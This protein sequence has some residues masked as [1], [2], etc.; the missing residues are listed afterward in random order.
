MILAMR[1]RRSNLL[2]YIILN[3]LVS[4]TTTWG[5]LSA[6]DYLH[7]RSEQ[8]VQG[9]TIMTRAAADAIYKP[10]I[11]ATQPPPA[12]LTPAPADAKVI[13]ISQ[14]IGAGDIN[15]EVVMLKRLGDGD[16]SLTG[17]TLKSSSGMVYSFPV[18]PQ[19]V[20]LFKGGAIQVY[21]RAGV[22]TATELYWNRTD[23]AWKP[24]DLLTL[25]DTQNRI[26]ATFKVP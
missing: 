26:Q 3:I 22:D 21:S 14:V 8:A 17:W 10:A 11:K 1:R 15:N 24:G 2:L 18:F 16:L 9:I 5:A 7:P 4:F 6:W 19:Q 23:P 12:A 13:E 25:S 20:V